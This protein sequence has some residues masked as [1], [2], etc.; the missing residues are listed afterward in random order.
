MVGV[1][2]IMAS[3]KKSREALLSSVPLTLQ[4]ANTDPRLS[5][6]HSGL[7][8]L[9]GHF[10]SVSCGVTAPFSWVLVHKVLF[11]PSKSLFPQ[12]CVSSGIKSHWLPK[13]NSLG[14][15]SPFARSPGWEICCGS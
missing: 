11:V 8:T 12:A 10:G 13:S 7:R 6:R 14:V 5:W 2:K 9:T 15:V 4:Q 3:F 1:K